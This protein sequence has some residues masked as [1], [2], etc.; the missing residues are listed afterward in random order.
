ME[1]H[2]VSWYYLYFLMLRNESTRATSIWCYCV[3][4][5]RQFLPRANVDK[6]P[7]GCAPVASS[8]QIT[9]D[10]MSAPVLIEISLGHDEPGKDAANEVLTQCA[11]ALQTG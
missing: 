11:P 7:L 10:K 1:F 4:P 3:K 6:G 8:V 2:L 9:Y 5:M